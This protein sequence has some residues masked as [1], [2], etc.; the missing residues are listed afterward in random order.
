MSG[1][2]GAFNTGVSTRFIA[3]ACVNC[4]NAV[5]GSNAPAS[6]GKFLTR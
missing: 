2:P 3:R 4:Y 5:H 6:R 1:T